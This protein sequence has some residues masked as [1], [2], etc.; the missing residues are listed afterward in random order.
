MHLAERTMVMIEERS[1]DCGHQA[2]VCSCGHGFAD[3]RHGLFYWFFL[4]DCQSDEMSHGWRRLGEIASRIQ[5]MTRV[6][7]TAGHSKVRSQMSA[8]VTRREKYAVFP[9]RVS[10]G[11]P[12]MSRS[13]E[14]TL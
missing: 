1:L 13:T 14:N 2:T 7:V 8:S 10:F 4:V 3:G 5:R 6:P 9:S 11:G 12:M